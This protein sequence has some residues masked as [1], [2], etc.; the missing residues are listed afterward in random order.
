MYQ[1]NI[2]S[3]IDFYN[4]ARF[5]EDRFHPN[6]FQ[7]TWTFTDHNNIPDVFHGFI[8]RY[9]GQYR[10]RRVPLDKINNILNEIWSGPGSLEK[11][12][13]LEHEMKVNG[14]D[15]KF[16]AADLAVIKAK[17]DTDEEEVLKEDELDIGF[18]RLDDNE[19]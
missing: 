10:I 19:E 12:F 11:I 14:K 18:S 16:T 7:G 4:Q 3:K 1:T 15:V 5:L 6:G 13:R 17:K 9:F 8:Q 2:E